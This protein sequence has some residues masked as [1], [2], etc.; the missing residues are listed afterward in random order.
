M[1]LLF[2]CAGHSV[3]RSEIQYW[4]LGALRILL[5]AAH[6]QRRATRLV[7]IST[8]NDLRCEYSW[9]RHTNTSKQRGLRHEQQSNEATR[10][11]GALRKQLAARVTNNHEQRQTG[12]ARCE[13]SWQ[14]RTSNDEQRGSSGTALGANCA[15]DTAGSGAQATRLAPRAQLTAR[16]AVN[17]ASKQRPHATY[18]TTRDVSAGSCTSADQ[19]QNPDLSFAPISA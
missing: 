4:Q 15:A 7:T 17:D 14:R 2:F 8:G 6:E 16:I 19:P 10:Q 12:Q 1:L 5:A 13:N 3:P 11:R 9:Q 18:L